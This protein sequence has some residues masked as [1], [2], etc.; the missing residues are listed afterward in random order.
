MKNAETKMNNKGFSLILVIICM[1]LIGVLATM[2][3]STSVNNVQMRV[4]EED[5]S[6][7]FYSAEE[8]LDE[9]RANVEKKANEAL[10]SAYTLFLQKYAATA[11]KNRESVFVTTFSQELNNKFTEDFIGTLENPFNM[12]TFISDYLSVADGSRS[13]IEIG[14]AG[15]VL[16]EGGSDSGKITIKDLSIT[17]TDADGYKTTIKTDLVVKVTYPKFFEA[18][19]AGPAFLDYSVITDGNIIKDNGATVSTISGCIYSGNSLVVTNGANLTVQSPYLIAKNEINV[20]KNSTLSISKGSLE[21]LQYASKKDT[22]LWT[23]NIMTT[24]ENR[25]ETSVNN[26]YISNIDCYVQDDLTINGIKDTVV[27]SGGNYYGY[28]SG[29]TDAANTNSA[30]NINARDIDLTISGLNNLWLAGQS[31]I[32]VPTGYGRDVTEDVQASVMQGESVS[33]KGNQAAYLL[34]GDCIENVWHNPMTRAEYDA[35]LKEITGSGGQKSLIL[36]TRKADSV[37]GDIMNLDQYLDMSSKAADGDY[38][39]RYTPVFV[40]YAQGGEMVYVYMNFSTANAAKKYFEEYYSI[41]KDLVDTRMETIGTGSILVNDINQITATGN[42]VVH[43]EGGGNPNTVIHSNSAATDS[44]VRERDYAYSGNFRNLTM[45]LDARTTYYGSGDKLT[46]CIFRFENLDALRILA[47]TAP[48]VSVE[49]ES[50]NY[51]LYV[52]NSDPYVIDTTRN[53]GLVLASGD[54]HVSSSFTGLIIT[55]GEVKVAEGV[56]ITSAPKAMNALITSNEDLQSFFKYYD[57]P[58]AGKENKEAVDIYF[59][60]WQ[61]N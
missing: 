38:R 33:F 48:G 49:H 39:S 50:T 56:S 29:L 45:S 26:L 25:T 17:Y 14:Q 35:A 22:G 8:V 6:D 31:Y 43:S 41:N 4:M 7:N 32:S 15:D 58:D 42:L 12:S 59:D 55:Q 10:G 18:N 36:S 11:P 5:A 1:T 53:C 3:I 37:N 19:T 9:I 44:Q 51:K 20:E 23:Q 2:I 28:G 54:V 34:P 46:D 47:N 27:L 61:K 52:A 16:S 60:N 13:G 24:P 21:D 57:D 40:Q 30:I